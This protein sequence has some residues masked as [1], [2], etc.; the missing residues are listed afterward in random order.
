MMIALFSM[1]GMA[2]AGVGPL[3]SA[4]MDGTARTSARRHLLKATWNIFAWFDRPIGNIYQC[5]RMARRFSLMFL[6]VQYR[7]QLGLCTIGHAIC[8]CRF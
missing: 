5:P 8:I 2:T 3:E 4:Q 7:G 1:L 6:R